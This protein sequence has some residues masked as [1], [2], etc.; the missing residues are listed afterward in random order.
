MP[1]G[2][3]HEPARLLAFALPGV[4]RQ[5]RLDL[6]PFPGANRGRCFHCRSWSEVRH[7]IGRHL[8]LGLAAIQFLS[9]GIGKQVDVNF[10]VRCM[11]RTL[12]LYI[13]IALE[14]LHVE[15][16]VG[17]AA[18]VDPRRCQVLG[19]AVELVG[20]VIVARM[21]DIF[22]INLRGRPPP[23]GSAGRRQRRPPPPRCG[24][25]VL[26]RNAAIVG[27]LQHTLH[28]PRSQRLRPQLLQPLRKTE[29]AF[30]GSALASGCRG[31]CRGGP[32]QEV[33]VRPRRRRG[34]AK[35]ANHVVVGAAL[36]AGVAILFR[37]P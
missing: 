17:F 1:L 21:A 8:A 27:G 11:F 36:A 9:P 14:A 12:L 13:L 33:V 5:V 19:H 29:G 15:A 16:L 6:G 20:K 37:R 28:A 35:V 4:R 3:Y 18:F 26:V 22:R 32:R 23:L 31:G 10:V 7:A 2:L 25:P 24:L 30:A 34:G